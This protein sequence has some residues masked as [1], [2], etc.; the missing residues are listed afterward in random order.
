VAALD[1]YR[2]KIGTSGLAALLKSLRFSLVNDLEIEY[3]SELHPEVETMLWMFAR[4]FKKYITRFV[5]LA[6]VRTISRIRDQRPHFRELSS[7]ILIRVLQTLGWFIDY[8]ETLR[9]LEEHT[10]NGK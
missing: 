4:A 2:N 9:M 3:Q 1:L 7:D 10:E 8:Q 5:C 6:S